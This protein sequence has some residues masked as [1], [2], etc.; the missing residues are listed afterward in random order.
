MDPADVQPSCDTRERFAV[1]TLHGHIGQRFLVTSWTLGPQSSN[2]N[3]SAEHSGKCQNTFLLNLK[4]QE[5]MTTAYSS[6]CSDCYRICTVVPPDFATVESRTHKCLEVLRPEAVAIT[7]AA[8]SLRSVTWPAAAA[9]LAS[10]RGLP[11]TRHVALLPKLDA[12]GSSQSVHCVSCSI[13]SISNPGRHA[14]LKEVSKQLCCSWVA[15]LDV[16]ADIG[17]YICAVP[18]R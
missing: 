6:M 18:Q 14:Q 1:R 15:H 10:E 13:S 4:R 3:R 11:E 17:M 12:S 16:L 5:R 7:A 8:H 2:E 9:L